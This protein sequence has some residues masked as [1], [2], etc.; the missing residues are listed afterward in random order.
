MVDI[1]SL[2]TIVSEPTFK[3]L[4]KHL[5]NLN[6]MYYIYLYNIFRYMYIKKEKT[7]VETINSWWHN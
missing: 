2:S 1:N 7:S 6:Y 3:W 5:Y 4:G